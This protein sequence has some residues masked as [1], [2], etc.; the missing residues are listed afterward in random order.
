MPQQCFPAWSFGTIINTDGLH[1]TDTQFPQ[2]T[3]TISQK[4]HPSNDLIRA[5]IFDMD[6]TLINST[7]TDYLSWQRLFHAVTFLRELNKDRV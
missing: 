2:S 7:Y 5:I 1:E 3:S 6:G 4:M